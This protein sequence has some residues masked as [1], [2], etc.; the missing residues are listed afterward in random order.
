VLRAVLLL[1]IVAHVG[2]VAVHQF[3]W[4]TGLIRRMTRPE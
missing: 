3:V 2:A 1:L 4:K